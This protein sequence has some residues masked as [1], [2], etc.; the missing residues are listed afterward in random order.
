MRKRRR[1]GRLL[2]SVHNLEL[3]V[4]D[5][6][7]LVDEIRG[8]GLHGVAELLHQVG[9]ISERQALRLDN[10]LKV[11]GG[12]VLQFFVGVVVAVLKGEL[13]RFLLNGR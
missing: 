6:L 12:Q 1:G 9:D 10:L 7:D 13:K 2:R 11:Q 4:E 5:L 8:V 3:H